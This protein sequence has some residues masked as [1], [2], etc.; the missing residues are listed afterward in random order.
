MVGKFTKLKVKTGRQPVAVAAGMKFER[1]RANLGDV[2]TVTSPVV[3]VRTVTDDLHIIRA[4]RDGILASRQDG[5]KWGMKVDEV[6]M[7]RTLAV[8]GM[9]P[10]LSVRTGESATNVHPGRRFIVYKVKKG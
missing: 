3:E 2:L 4:T 6:M 10:P 8:I 5:L 1:W 7:D 9:L